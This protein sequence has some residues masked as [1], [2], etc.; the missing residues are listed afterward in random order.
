[1]QLFSIIIGHI[2]AWFA[3]IWL[4]YMNPSVDISWYTPT[5]LFV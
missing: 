1:M 3:I 5:I 4:R 2:T